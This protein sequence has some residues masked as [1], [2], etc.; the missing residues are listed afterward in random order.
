MKVSYKQATKF[1][2][3]V[4]KSYASSLKVMNLEKRYLKALCMP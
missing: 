1:H 3:D 2:D 4:M